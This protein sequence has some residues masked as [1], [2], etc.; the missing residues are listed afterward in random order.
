[1]V[2]LKGYS[3]WPSVESI[4]DLITD[5]P[6]NE[7][8]P[9]ISI[10]TPNYNYGHLIDATIRSVLDQGYPNLEYIL[11]DDGSTD[12]SLH[13]IRKYESK[14]AYFEQ[15]ENRGQYP[16]INKGF[17]KATGDICGWINSDDIY[18]PWT[19]RAVA[20]I[21][22]Q[23]PEVD[24]IMGA[25]ASIQNGIIHSVRPLTPYPREMVRAGLFHGGE[26]GYGYIQQESCFWRRR[27]W[28]KAGGLDEGL[29]YAAD[30]ELWTRFAEHA[31]LY[32]VS[33]VLSGFTHR[34]FNNRSLA[35]SERY[36]GEVIK[37]TDRLRQ[38][39]KSTESKLA[40]KIALFKKADGTFLPKAIA[41]RLLG[42]KQ[43]RGPVLQWSFE[44]SRYK[45]K[46]YSF[47]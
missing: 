26:L 27:L 43:L 22:A 46:E 12:D 19:L 37:V 31:D 4:H 7:T 29:R 2:S 41:R 11:I 25:Q 30:F 45:L 42:V 13:V 36:L 17:S 24:W 10:V 14:L 21:F 32:S 16:T 47:F 35:N 1:M 40:R 44:H 28:E 8:W 38:D 5:L 23:F 6:E 18:L 3:V 39:P 15:H 34:G 20:A 9:K 33:S